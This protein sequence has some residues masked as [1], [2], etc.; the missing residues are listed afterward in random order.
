MNKMQFWTTFIL[1]LI[2]ALSWTPT[3]IKFLK[4][5]KLM[6]KM[7][8]RYSNLN[9]DKTQTFFL[10]KL[11]IL[12]KNKSFNLKQI[13]CEIEDLDGNKFLAPAGNYRIVV[14][15]F[16]DRPQKLLLVINL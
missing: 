9:K 16:E 10:F 5:N 14:F 3:I 1:A 15:T 11:S 6:G 13:K 4:P 7:I 2:G 8:S 12:S